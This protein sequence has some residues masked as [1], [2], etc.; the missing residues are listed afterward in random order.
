MENENVI[1]YIDNV[2]SFGI[3]T[4][5]RRSIIITDKRILILNISSTSSVAT[6]AAFAYV[7][8]IFGRRMANKITK[9]DIENAT[10]KF[11][12]MNLD[13]ALKSDPDNL[14][15]NNEDII[16]IEINRYNIQIKT[17]EKTYRYGLSNPDIKNKDSDVYS[18]Y[19]QALKTAFGDKVK[20]N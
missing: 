1:G 4:P 2:T 5:K 7:F 16:N 12:Q 19:V 3:I 18:S 17:N 11:S 8:G 20:A 14:A 6:D 10:K 9:E 13:D 15:L